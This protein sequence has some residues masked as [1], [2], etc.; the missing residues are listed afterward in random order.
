M[1]TIALSAG[2]T[3]PSKELPSGVSVSLVP[4]ITLPN[5]LSLLGETALFTNVVEEVLG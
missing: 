4:A 5:P 3:P 1:L 2:R